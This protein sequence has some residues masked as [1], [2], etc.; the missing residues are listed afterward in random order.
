L[1]NFF[2]DNNYFEYDNGSRIY[3]FAENFKNDKDLD[4]F[5]GLET[6]IFLLEQMEELQQ[7]TFLKAIERC[8]SHYLRGYDNLPGLI[9][10][11]FNPTSGWLKEEIYEKSKNNTFIFFHLPSMQAEALGTIPLEIIR[12]T[13][14]RISSLLTS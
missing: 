11:T 7:A 2:I 1:I 9:L 5:K 14:L 10:G 13:V 6:N 4:R 12:S 8:G 3:F